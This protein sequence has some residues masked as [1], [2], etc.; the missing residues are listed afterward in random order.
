LFDAHHV[1]RRAWLQWRAAF[2]VN[3]Q[4][5]AS[6]QQQL[7]AIRRLRLR[8]ALR[9]WRASTRNSANASTAASAAAT[10]ASV[11]ASYSIA[12]D[13]ENTRARTKSL[14]A[15]YAT[16]RCCERAWLAWRSAF[17]VQCARREK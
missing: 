4:R 7:L 1:T 14:A 16:A 11:S 13:D 8:R 17:V 3:K 12:S 5:T 15:A 6:E 9:Q 2:L 10:A